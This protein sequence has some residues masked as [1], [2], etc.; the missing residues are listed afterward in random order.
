MYDMF[1]HHFSPKHQDTVL[2]IGV[3][4]DQSYISSNYFESLYPW[5]ESITAVGLDDAHFLTKKYPGLNFVRASGC[6]LPFPDKSFDIVH[7]SAVLEH[8]GNITNQQKMIAEALR[9]ARNG[10]FITTPNRWFPIEF[11][12]LIP[13]FHWLPKSMHRKFLRV[14]GLNFFAE[15]KNLNLTSKKELENIFCQYPDWSFNIRTIKL[16]GMASNLILIGKKNCS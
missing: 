15:E 13:L 7:S 9:V 10:I 6:L 16:L 11:H 2:D 14:L 3:T 12:T 4:E 5:K 1:I 8:V